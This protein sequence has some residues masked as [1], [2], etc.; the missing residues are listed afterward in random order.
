M[1]FRML[2]DL[3][4]MVV[5]ALL[6]NLITT[7]P[8]VQCLVVEGAAQSLFAVALTCLGRGCP[9][10]TRGLSASEPLRLGLSFQFSS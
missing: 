4:M 2:L 1:V 3:A 10:E 6:D 9:Q 5:Q 8:K 7:R